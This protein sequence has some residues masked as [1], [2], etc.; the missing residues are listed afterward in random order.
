MR[1]LP[2]STIHSLTTSF[3]E[4]E[5]FVRHP[6]DACV[7][8]GATI[9]RSDAPGGGQAFTEQLYF[10]ADLGC[11]TFTKIVTGQ[12]PSTAVCTIPCRRESEP[13]GAAGAGQPQGIR[14]AN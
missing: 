6:N 10:S 4:N 7:F 3:V 5:V 1:A 9:H 13:G 2:R 11:S 12:L 14:R 8:S